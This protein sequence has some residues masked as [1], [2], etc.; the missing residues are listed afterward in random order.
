VPQ[1]HQS[2]RRIEDHIKSFP[3]LKAAG[4]QET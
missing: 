3:D 2:F 4:I 1:T